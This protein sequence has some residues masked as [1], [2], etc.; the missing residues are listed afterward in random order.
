MATIFKNNVVKCVCYNVAGI[1]VS[2][3]WTFAVLALLLSGVIWFPI[4]SVRNAEGCAL[5]LNESFDEHVGLSWYE[6]YVYGSLL[7]VFRILGW[8][9][10]PLINH[11]PMKYRAEFIRH[12]K[13]P[14]CEYSAKA[15]V[16]YFKSHDEKAKKKMIV[17]N[18]L[19]AE[20]F[21]LIWHDGLE[22]KTCITSG[23]ELTK[24]QVREVVEKNGYSCLW[25]DYFKSHTP[26]KEM[27]AMLTQLAKKGY[28]A[29]IC[30]IVAYIR[31][32]R[33]NAEMV[34]SLLSCGNQDLFNKVNEIMGEYCDLDAVEFCVDDIDGFADKDEKKKIVLQSWRN[35]CENKKNICT[36]AQKKM[37][38]EQYLI[39]AETGH[40]LNYDAM[41]TIC[42]TIKDE[43][44]LKD[45]IRHEFRYISSSLETALKFHYWRYCVYLVVKQ[46]FA[47]AKK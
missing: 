40:H 19:S 31:Q 27:V 37:S 41:Q 10:A 15:Q 12:G 6:H 16:A 13:K 3:L 25:V 1:A 9:F 35:Y 47:K 2:V 14:L 34:K 38:H 45:V 46:E 29:A 5:K 33:P 20:A 26:D 18:F 28:A 24:E 22:L 32:Q 23:I 36:A 30:I 44:F 42:L 8:L 11:L 17:D 4:H 39:F 43:D 21:D 7:V